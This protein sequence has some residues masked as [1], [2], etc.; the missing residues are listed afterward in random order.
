MKNSG[1]KYIDFEALVVYLVL[2][3]LDQLFITRVSRVLLTEQITG[4]AVYAGSTSV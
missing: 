4:Q 1:G 2:Y 3:I